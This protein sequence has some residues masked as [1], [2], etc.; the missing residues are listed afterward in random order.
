MTSRE[1]FDVVIVGT[2]TAGEFAAHRLAARGKR[3]AVVE[4]ER[5]EGECAYWA[6]NPSK[7]LLRP[8]ALWGESVKC[9]GTEPVALNWPEISDYRDEMVRHYDDSVFAGRLDEAGITLVRADGRLDG[10]GRVVAGDRILT[11]PDIVIATGSE[12]VIPPIDGLE[13]AGYWTNREAVSVTEIPHSLV[14]IGGG[15]VAVELGQM[16]RRY[17]ATVT[18]VEQADTLFP[19]E[20]P[21]LGELLQTALE[22]DGIEVRLGTVVQ[23]VTREGDSRKVLLSDGTEITAEHVVV[24]TGRRPRSAGI[25]LETV[26]IVPGDDGGVA[27]D[28]YGR[29]GEGLWAIG[30][31]TGPPFFTHRAMYHARCIAA[32]IVEPSRELDERATPRVVFTDPELSAVGMT[33]RQARENGIDVL[34]ASLPFEELDRPYTYQTDWS[35]IGILVVERSTGKVLGAAAAGPLTSEFIHVAAVAIKARL[36]YTELRDLMFQFPTFSEMYWHLGEELD[37]LRASA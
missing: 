3:V 20:E 37:R 26:G 35:G 14:F 6:C 1:D 18:I 36:P 23:R 8:V 21:A 30:D 25:G 5:I 22:A 4:R 12:A 13:R 28:G 17:G 34:S 10:P 11:A 32:N 31:V 2:G 15:P 9:F 16:L 24:A 7:T 29:A 19:R 33:E 27:V